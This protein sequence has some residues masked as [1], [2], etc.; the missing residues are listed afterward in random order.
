[1][2]EANSST[3]PNIFRTAVRNLSDGKMGLLEDV[4]ENWKGELSHLD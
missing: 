1:M 2:E 3:N 4:L